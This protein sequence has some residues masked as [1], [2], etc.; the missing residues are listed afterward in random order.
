MTEWFEQWFG[1]EYLH[2]YGHRDDEDAAALV[3]LIATVVPLRGRLLLDLACGPGRHATQFREQAARVVG[4]DLSMPLLSRARHRDGG[5][6]LPLVRGDMRRLPFRD[7]VFDI[8]VNLFTSFGYFADDEQHEIA[9]GRAASVLRPGGT[10]V[11][12]FL[13]A[14]AVRAS[15]VPREELEV[16]ERRVAVERSISADGRHVIK[17]IH[18]VD[19]HRSF[20]ERVRLFEQHQLEAMFQTAGL[21]VRHRLGDYNGGQIN[22]TSPRVILI[23]ERL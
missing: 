12:D 17:E 19:D 3:A 4:F 21:A 8:V 7:G 2:L 9:L 13:H 11:L 23:G 15:L 10:F 18:L 5:Q 14:D 1:E 6:P 16:G 22:D 20:I